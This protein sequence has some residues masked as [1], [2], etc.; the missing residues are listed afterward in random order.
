MLLLLS[1][2]AVTSSSARAQSTT[3]N[4]RPA[5][6]AYAGLISE[7][8]RFDGA[9]V[10][11]QEEESW[12]IGMF[13]G[14]WS[15]GYATKTLSQS[16]LVLRPGSTVRVTE[17]QLSGLEA[18]RLIRRVG[19]LQLAGFVTAGQA[20][21]SA[22][23]ADTGPQQSTSASGSTFVIEPAVSLGVAVGPILRLDARV[24]ARLGGSV[25]LSEQSIGTSGGFVGVTG[26]L[27]W[28]GDWRMKSR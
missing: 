2:T 9:R 20:R 24:G 19:P 13:V 26:A 7:I 16:V 28:L 5:L 17:L 22:A 3:D 6:G 8:S 12:R 18:G 25:K 27:G 15:V 23:I 11:A 21:V 10:R 14:Q 4:T 1:V